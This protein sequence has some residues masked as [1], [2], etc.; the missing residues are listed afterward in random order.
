SPRAPELAHRRTAA[1]QFDWSASCDGN[2]LNSSI[3][4]LGITCI[5]STRRSPDG[6]THLSIDLRAS[7]GHAR[8]GAKKIN[9][10]ARPDRASVSHRGLEVE[11][12]RI[13]RDPSRLHNFRLR[14]R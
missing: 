14:E 4:V 1:A 5:L 11:G 8:P 13:F 2:E 9:F 3:L 6:Y 12:K 10:I 7:V